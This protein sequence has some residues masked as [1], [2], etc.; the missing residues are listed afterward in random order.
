MQVII[1]N[2]LKMTIDISNELNK[3]SLDNY[4]KKEEKK[5]EKEEKNNNINKQSDGLSNR[6]KQMSNEGR[7]FTDDST[8]SEKRLMKAINNIILYTKEK[9]K[10]INGDVIHKNIITLY[11]CQEY[12]H[13]IGGPEPN[14]EN[15]KVYMKPDGGILFANIKDEL[16]PLLIVEDKVQGTNDKLF[17]K[18]KKRQA[19]GNAIERAAK[20]IRGAEMIFSGMN[21]FPYVLFASGCDFHSSETISK[22]FEMMNMGYPN[23]YIDLNPNKNNEEIEESIENELQNIIIIKRNKINIVSIF[24][25][26]HK[27][28]EME[29][30]SSLWKTEEYEKILCRIIDIVLKEL[31]DI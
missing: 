5:E 21:I 27:W 10:K 1:E 19:T 11:D 24:I 22:R 6:I 25:K 28:N 12:F 4:L 17:S 3:L 8:I 15:K 16:I 9:L 26:A 13:K 20:N 18:N 14:P 29:H 7:H 23:H 30:N 31:F 2:I